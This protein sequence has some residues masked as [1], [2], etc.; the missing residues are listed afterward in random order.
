MKNALMQIFNAKQMPEKY[1]ALHFCEGVANYEGAGKMLFISSDTAKKMDASF[2]GKPVFVGHQDYSV[3]DVERQA[4]GWVVRSF[5]N[6]LDGKH[7]AEILITTDK[8]HEAIKKGWAVSNSYIV[9]KPGPGGVWHDV[10]YDQEVLEATYDHLGLV[11]NPRYTE[12]IILTP[13]AFKKYNDEKQAELTKI[14]NSKGDT[15][16][17]LFKIFNKTEVKDAAEMAKMAVLLPKSKVEMTLEKIINAMDEIEST[18]NDKKVANATDIV[19]VGE[20]EMTVKDLI[21]KFQNMSEEAEKAKNEKDKEENEKEEDDEDLKKELENESEE[22]ED[23][24]ENE[25]DEDKK[26]K[27]NEKEEKAKKDNSSEKAKHAKELKE[28]HKVDNASDDET[29]AFETSHAMVARGA[30]R[31]GSK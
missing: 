30:N 15:T 8:G 16:M 21:E 18:K 24:K 2:V 19:K 22:D 12:S 5:Y 20:T 9:E 10:A 3:A 29:P 28:A 26:K 17:S 14:A 23:K 1:Y 31:Y 27:E 7:W 13:D 25:A 6:P 4:D 11:D